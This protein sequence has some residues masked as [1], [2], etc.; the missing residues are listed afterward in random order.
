MSKRYVYFC[1]KDKYYKFMKFVFHH[2][3]DGSLY[4]TFFVQN[5]SQVEENVL[6]VS[7][8]STGRVNYQIGKLE[9]TIFIDPVYN[10]AKP[11]NLLVS[12]I[13]NFEEAFVYLDG[14]NEDDLVVD[15]N[16]SMNYLNLIITIAPINYSTIGSKEIE[17]SRVRFNQFFDLIINSISDVEVYQSKLSEC[18]FVI[19]AI[20]LYNSQVINKNEALINFHQKA[21]NNKDSIIYSPNSEGVWKIIHSVPMRIPPALT[22]QFENTS[23]Q[24]I[25]I[26]SQ[27]SVAITKFLV[28]DKFQNTVKHFVNIKEIELDSEL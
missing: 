3:I 12:R 11:F 21:N 25:K 4:F 9:V 14:I 8:H 15:L 23:Y 24:A 27:S 22:I 2:H 20:G 13:S 18:G 10:V 16:N 19:P 1:T 5:Q 28:K 6:K 26:D 7:Y 17:L